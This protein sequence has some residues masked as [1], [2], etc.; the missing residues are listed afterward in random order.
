V[1]SAGELALV[2][3]AALAAGALNAVAGGGTLITFPTLTALGIAPI[4]ANVTN[5]V[6]LTPGYLGGALAQRADLGEQRRRTAGLSLIGVAG[7]LVGGVLLLST[8]E[9]R[10]EASVPFLILFATGLLAGQERI[11]ARLTLRAAHGARLHRIGEPAGVFLGAVYGGYFGGGLGIVLLA[12]LGLVS[13]TP[14]P[15]L[16]AVKQTIAFAVNVAAAAVFVFAADVAWGAALAMTG[17]SLLGGHFG[18][19][20]AG[21]V[22]PGALRRIVV[23]IGL[24]VSVAYLVT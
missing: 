10:F 18:G 13:D 4:T 12:V 22:P 2:A 11:R 23:G 7:G 20:L 5:A 3:L 15:K 21:R 6:A 1:L 16:N 14:L 9:E 17:G 19:S 24:I 8:S